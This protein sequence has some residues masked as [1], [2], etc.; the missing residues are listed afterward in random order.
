[1]TYALYFLSALSCVL[2]F[3]N[4]ALNAQFRAAKER[5]RKAEN[6]RSCNAD[7][8]I[9]SIEAMATAAK[10]LAAWNARWQA[11]RKSINDE[12]SAF[13]RTCKCKDV[14]M[15]AE[16]DKIEEDNPLS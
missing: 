16:L 3:W 12:E 8:L 15:N 7:M 5:A 13:Y 14:H 2:I 11:L 10:K 9:V 4:W 6:S 1:M